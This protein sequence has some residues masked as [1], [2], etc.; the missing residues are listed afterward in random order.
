MNM[1]SSNIRLRTPGADSTIP[2]GRTRAALVIE[3]L[4]SA[5]AHMVALSTFCI[6]AETAVPVAALR[7]GRLDA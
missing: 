1:L 3:E 7:A 6:Q 5:P 2:A 4:D